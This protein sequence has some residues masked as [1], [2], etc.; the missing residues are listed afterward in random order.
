M[1]AGILIFFYPNISDYVNSFSQTRSVISY[2]DSVSKIDKE[3]IEK[4]REN[5][6]AYNKKIS[7]EKDAIYIPNIIEGYEENL[8]PFNNG[9]MGNLIIEKINVNLPIYHGVNEG[10]IQNA[11]GHLPG[12]SLPIGGES[13]HAVLSTHTGLPTASLF[14]NLS[15]VKKGDE[16]VISILGEDLYYK[17]DQ[18]KKVKP[19]ELEDLKVVETKDYVT[20]FTCTPY[21]VNTHRLL[22]RGE[23]I[24]KDKSEKKDLEKN[25]KLSLI[26]TIL[27]LALITGLILIILITIIRDLIHKK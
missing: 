12:S 9:M 11:V 25:T 19:K 6:K 20:L 4:I 24:Y 8:N 21:G 2:K 14:T 1:I 27:K 15:K 23:R 13:T 7:E 22:V 26:T 18:I 16:F 10:V 3:K 5:A 17:V